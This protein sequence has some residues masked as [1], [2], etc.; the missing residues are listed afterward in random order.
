MRRR[1]INSKVSITWG[2]FLCPLPRSQR[3]PPP[4]RSTPLWAQRTPRPTQALLVPAGEHHPSVLPRRA[5]ALRPGSDRD[6]GTWGDCHRWGGHHPA[7]VEPE[8]PR[9]GPGG[10]KKGSPQGAAAPRTAVA[11][12]HPPR[13]LP[14]SLPAPARPSCPIFPAPSR[15]PPMHPAPLIPAAECLSL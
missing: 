7:D 5:P 3:P 9:S 2:H 15:C 14:Q 11:A 8:L 13:A 6:A 4:R 1:L 12:P 10:G